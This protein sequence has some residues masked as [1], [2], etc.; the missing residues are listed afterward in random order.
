MFFMLMAVFAITSCQSG[1]SDEERE[2]AKQMIDQARRQKN[3]ERILVLS[4]SLEKTGCMSEAR[5]CYWRGYAYDRMKQNEKA[6][7]EWRKAIELAMKAE[8]GEDID[9]YARAASYLANLLCVRGD[10]EGTLR[11]AEPVVEQLDTLKCDTTSDYENLLIYINC[12]RS[13]LGGSDKEIEEGFER[14]TDKHLENIKRNRT[15]ASYKNAIAGLINIAYNCVM[16]KK[17][18]YALSYTRNF[19]ELLAEYEQREGVSAEYVDRQLGRYDIYK[20][21]ALAGLGRQKEADEVFEAYLETNYSKTTEGQAMA[22]DYQAQIN[23]SA[24]TE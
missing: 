22:E 12:S 8:N 15:D 4:D 24:S 21:M 18:K 5:A 13:A 20:A 6:E 19:G 17:Y 23:A 7:S 2:Q 3:Y 11:L 16:L 10:F 9:V 14:A 1:V